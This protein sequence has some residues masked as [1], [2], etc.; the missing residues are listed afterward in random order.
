VIREN[1][2]V[3]VAWIREIRASLNVI[4]EIRVSFET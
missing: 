1:P 4:R 2:R 3:V